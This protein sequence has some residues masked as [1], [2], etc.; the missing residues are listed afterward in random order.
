MA[1]KLPNLIWPG[2]AKSVRF[3]PSPLLRS[4]GTR[5]VKLKPNGEPEKGQGLSGEE[6]SCN[7]RV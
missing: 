6:S 4:L 1:K 7:N 5:W 3:L 2:K